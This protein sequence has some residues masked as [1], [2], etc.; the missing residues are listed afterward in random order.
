H[1]YAAAGAFIITARLLHAEHIVGLGGT[2]LVVTVNAVPELCGTITPEPDRGVV[3]TRLPVDL[4]IDPACSFDADSPLANAR[5]DVSYGDGETRLDQTRLDLRQYHKRYAAPGRYSVAVTMRDGEG[6]TDSTHLVVAAQINYSPSIVFYSNPEAMG[7]RIDLIAESANLALNLGS[8]SDIDDDL[9]AIGHVSIDWGDGMQLQHEPFADVQTIGHQYAAPGYYHL[10]VEIEDG[11][12]EAQ[13]S[14]YVAVTP[15]QPPS[16][17]VTFTPPAVD[18]VVTGTVPL[19]VRFNLSCSDDPDGN[20][21][22][23]GV[24]LID[25]GDGGTA[26]PDRFQYTDFELHRYYTVGTFAAVVTITD[27]FGA[28]DVATY[29]IVVTP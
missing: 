29:S 14:Y 28:T 19:D 13:G 24:A 11:F 1:R 3:V 20:L 2:G 6:Q 22:E 25:F 17:C 18:G 27:R 21:Y 4:V 5:V 9:L 7:D 26:G 15:N 8:C 16:A 23:D 12:S 10:V